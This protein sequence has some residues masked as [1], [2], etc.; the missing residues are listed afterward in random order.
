VYYVRSFHP[1]PEM[2]P[3]WLGPFSTKK[4]GERVLISLTPDCFSGTY[5]VSPIY[6]LSY[7]W[8]T[9]LEYCA[10]P[11]EDMLL[12]PHKGLAIAARHGI[13]IP[14]ADDVCDYI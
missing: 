9:W 2:S 5:S 14:R 7:F 3:T 1:C 13:F 12:M 6:D 11:I 4:A 10:T 8:S